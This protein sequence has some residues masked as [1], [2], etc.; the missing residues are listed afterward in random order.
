MATLP[1]RLTSLAL[2]G[3]SNRTTAEGGSDPLAAA[4]KAVT[5]SGRAL[6]AAASRMANPVARSSGAKKPRWQDRAWSYYDDLGEIH[7]A[8]EFF[9]RNLGRVRLVLQRR[10]GPDEW[11]DVEG[12][13]GGALTQLARIRGPRGD[14]AEVQS[15]FGTTMF[16]AGEGYLVGTQDP[17]DATREVWEF[18]SADEFEVK[19]RDAKAYRK[20]EPM[21]RDKVEYDLVTSLT[22]SIGPREA[23]AIR[24]WEPHPRWSDLPVSPLMGVLSA[25]EELRLL[26]RAVRS[27]ARSR[28]ASAGILILPHEITDAPSNGMG[29]DAELDP[30]LADLIDTAATAIND[31]DSAAAAVPI[32]VRV[33]GEHADKVQHLNIVD[34]RVAY[35]ETEREMHVIRRIAQGLNLPPEVLLGMA[36]ANHWSAW[37]IDEAT[38]TQHIEPMAATLCANLTAAMV[39]PVAG[40]DFRVWYDDADLVVKP[41]RTGDAK[42]LH[43]RLA[44][45]DEALR[46]AGGWTEEDAPEDEERTRRIGVLLKDAKLAIDGEVTE[47]PAPVIAAPGQPAAPAGGQPGTTD[48]EP[49]DPAAATASALAVAHAR[50]REAAGSK[51]V[52]RLGR[53][54][55]PATEQVRASVRDADRGQVCAILGRDRIAA[56]GLD[57]T[58]L[59]RGSAS[60]LVG[61]GYPDD[62]AERVERHAAAHL[63]DT[64]PPPL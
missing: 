41:D 64:D 58:T 38:W 49:P 43:D 3:R 39:V 17:E 25:C 61:A 54:R 42:E 12:D 50:A 62:L 27:R 5:A 14:R 10:T 56:L 59:V 35:P 31:E 55:G 30:V 6:T 44:I 26:P 13:A 24:M 46:A 8:A 2:V 16:V 33:D 47:Q 4:A 36:D 9:G 32:V 34:A 57:P 15:T 19:P 7:E 18:L 45:S 63:F 53:A 22:E 51:A 37:Q 20:R 48:R 29:E 40:P 1:E 21:A 28:L 11:E 52:T 60:C 23:L